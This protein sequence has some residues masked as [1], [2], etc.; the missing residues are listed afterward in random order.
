MHLL[1]G[2]WFWGMHLVWWFFWIVL[3]TALFG[4]FVPVPRHRV[5]E[6]PVQVLQRRYAAGEISTEE[7]EERKKHLEQDEVKR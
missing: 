7:Y 1:N 3:I 2:G 6:T 4:L 5:R